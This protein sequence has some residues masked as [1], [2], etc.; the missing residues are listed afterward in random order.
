VALKG[1]TAVAAARQGQGRVGR[2]LTGDRHP[3]RYSYA[4]CRT[5]GELAGPSRVRCQRQRAPLTGIRTAVLLRFSET[6][7]PGAFNRNRAAINV[8]SVQSAGGLVNAGS[9]VGSREHGLYVELFEDNEVVHR[10]ACP[11]RA[12]EV[13]GSSG[14]GNVPEHQC[15]AT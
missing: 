1:S 6:R 8:Q 4:D 9:L 7:Q 14:T 12:S 11:H 15:R 3:N 5:G 10:A 13:A 2:Q